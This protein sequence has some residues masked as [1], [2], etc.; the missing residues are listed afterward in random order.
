MFSRATKNSILRITLAS[1]LLSL[2]L[3]ASRP[4]QAQYLYGITNGGSLYEINP[5][6]HSTTL[7]FTQP[8]TTMTSAN[9]LAWSEANQRMF[10][11]GTV[12]SSLNFYTWNR[13]TGV[14]TQITGSL[15]A[16]TVSNGTY[17]G[18]YYWYVNSNSDNLIRVSFDFS[19]PNAPKVASYMDFDHFG[20]VTDLGSYGF[21][22]ISVRASDGM[23]FGSSN[24]G[25]FRVNVATGIPIGF[26]SIN[27][28]TTLYQLGFGQDN[29]LYGEAS[30]SGAWY[31]MNTTTGNATS[32]GYS[33]SP[34]AFNDLSEGSVSGIAVPEPGSL[35]L[36]AL[37]GL[38]ALPLLRGKRQPDQ[39]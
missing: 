32:M 14:Q 31:T 6:S 5:V 23:L 2:A 16:G 33:S 36:L 28:N 19:N 38:G 3:I 17:Y 13:T 34:V 11:F 24:K 12:G 15:P 39:A 4:A 25:V 26:T 1:G 18:G 35:G 7:V 10:Y 8:L 22:D 37:A 29:V 27:S 21:G 9:G 30:A 20:G